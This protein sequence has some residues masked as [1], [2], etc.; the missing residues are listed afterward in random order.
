[1][2]SLVEELNNEGSMHCCYGKR[3]YVALVSSSKG[4]FVEDGMSLLCWNNE[5][6]MMGGWKHLMQFFGQWSL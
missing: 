2:V 3:K 1:M 6:R 4:L 5:G